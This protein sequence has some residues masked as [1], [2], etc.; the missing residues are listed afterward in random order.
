MEE[1]KTKFTSIELDY[2]KE[3]LLNHDSAISWSTIFE[4]KFSEYIGCKYSISCNSGTSGLH[5][6]LYAANIC[7]GDEVILPAL[8]VVMD[9]YVILHMGAIP[10]FADV[11]KETHLIDPED[12]QKKITKKTKAIITVSWEG[13][14][15]EMDIIND[16]AKKNNLIVID[17]SARTVDGFYKGIISGMAADIT[18]F[19]FESKK[20]L[21]C[22]GEGGMITTNQPLLAERA[23]KFS[24]IGYK[25]LTASAGETHLARSDVQDPNYKRFDTL[26]L[27]Y[28]L[29][30]ISAAIGIGQLKRVKEIVSRRKEIGNLFKNNIEGKYEWFIPQKTPLYIEHAY[31]TF[32]CEYREELLN[33]KDWKSFY[34]EFIRRGG[35]GF[36][37]CVANPYLETSLYPIYKSQF[38]Q[39][40][41]L[42]PN[43]EML[44]RNVMCFK[45]NY[46]DIKK[47]K[48]QVN[49]LCELLDDWI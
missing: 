33:G 2:V 9:A 18:V 34:N 19:S 6:A 5:A 37:A 13:Q 1:T 16:I 42:C 32:S 15:C 28:R 49:L 47:A 38:N 45:T 40:Y 36:Y 20:H 8:T 44:Q 43:A 29:N 27:N 3:C 41:C 23:R 26:G 11:D 35:D 46:R 12:I 48:N 21:T 7:K 31:Y 4:T 25:H 17:D 10:V 22:G 14:M 39:K 24:G 30:D